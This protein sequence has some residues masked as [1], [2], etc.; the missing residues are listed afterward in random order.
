MQTSS[1]SERDTIMD[2]NLGYR[3]CVKRIDWQIVPPSVQ[4]ALNAAPTKKAD[5]SLH[6]PIR[7]RFD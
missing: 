5:E 7:V 6:R 4:S 3:R 1:Q 2:I